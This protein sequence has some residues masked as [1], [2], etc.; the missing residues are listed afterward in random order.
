MLLLTV[1]L[2]FGSIQLIKYR[3]P[4]VVF[5]PKGEPNMI[6]VYVSLPIGTDIHY[7]D[8]ITHILEDRV[9]KVI[10]QNNPIVKSVITNVAIG[11]TDPN[12]NDN[13]TYSNKSKI[14]V[15]F[16]DFSKRNGVST[17]KY[18]DS[19][20]KAVQG[21]PGVE[22]SV[23]Q[24][25]NG[26]PTG[27]PINI[28]I[29]GDNYPQLVNTSQ[30][31]LHY[32]DSMNIPGVEEL[33]S[34]L[35]KNKPEI[36]FDIDRER[37]N[38]EGVSTGQIGSEIRTAV[39]GN[40]ASKYRDQNDEYPIMIRYQR[41]QREDVNALKNLDITFRDMNMHGDIRQIPISTFANIH[42][43]R[44]YGAITRLNEKPII[45]LSS[46]VLG[47]FNA[48]QVVSQITAAIK[49]FHT[50]NGVAIE[51]TGEQQDQKETQDFLSLALG[52]AVALIFVILISQF[53]SVAKPLIILS[54]VIFCVIGIILGF[55]ITKMDISI[56]MCG[57][58][59]VALAGLVVRNGILLVEFADMLMKQGS[60][61]LDAAIEAGKIRMTPVLL[62]AIAAILGLIPLAVG[63]NIDFVTLF[64]NFNPHI[65][66]GGD[67]V[68]FW[69]PLSWTMIFGLGFATFLTLLLVPVMYYGL[70]KVRTYKWSNVMKGRILKNPFSFKG[71]IRRTEYVLSLI[72]IMVANAIITKATQGQSVMV[73][74]ILKNIL[75]GPVVWF[76]LAQAAKR[77]HDIGKNGWWQLI[78]I[79]SLLLIDQAGDEGT[80]EYGES[81]KGKKAIEEESLQL[82]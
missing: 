75:E 52:I 9:Y 2:F 42:Y 14:D 3:T 60:N 80:N 13:G 27:K 35:Q 32:L 58:G 7:T 4:N 48:N 11:A 57:L 68:A 71:R 17:A 1:I 82:V 73:T 23:D 22:L 56:V 28:E 55:S 43:G 21:L 61:A 49:N 37:A 64:T 25:K 78:P 81:P 36:V 6:D 16:V 62:T 19:I 18:L 66:F 30:D 10:G 20:Q 39:Y 15:A 12:D 31:L 24:E 40:E 8:S 29:R 54:E 63:F 44:T 46:N 53:N 5:F 69:G 45:T 50:P 74:M 34:D 47:G 26:P 72:I 76:F 38:Y 59:F 77:C 67:S 79:W 41:N 65:F 33:K 51:L 70:D